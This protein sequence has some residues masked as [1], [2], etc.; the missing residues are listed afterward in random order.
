M[1]LANFCES[2]RICMMFSSAVCS[3]VIAFPPYTTAL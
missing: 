2:W 1:S 3:V